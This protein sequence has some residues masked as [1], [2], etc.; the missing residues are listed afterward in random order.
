M[1]IQDVEEDDLSDDF[2]ARARFSLKTMMDSDG[3]HFFHRRLISERRD[4][5]GKMLALRPVEENIPAYADARAR[6]SFIDAILT[7]SAGD[8][9]E[10]LYSER[11]V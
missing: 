2:I 11:S 10:Y 4:Q 6:I 7:M 5:I 1:E 8:I 3:W 9:A